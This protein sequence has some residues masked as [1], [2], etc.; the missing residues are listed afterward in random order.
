M[1]PVTPY[2][3]APLPLG[4]VCARGERS[5]RLAKPIGSEYSLRSEQENI[6]H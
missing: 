3:T 4:Y 1:T 6:S 5:K 2:S